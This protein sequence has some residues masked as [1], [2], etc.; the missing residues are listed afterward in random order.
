[1][2]KRI[3]SS[4]LR[5]NM[6]S[7]VAATASSAIILAIRYP[8]YLRFLGYEQY[9]VWLV[10]STVLTFAQL[11][12][13]GVDHAVM[14]LVAEEHGRRN[15]VAVQEYVSSAVAILA[16][17][18]AAVLSLIIT[19]RVPIIAVFKLSQENASHA[20]WLV[21]C[22]GCLS[23]YV[24]IVQTLSATLSGLGRMDLVN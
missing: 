12:N 4:Q 1:M 2:F 19:F 6:V 7:G 3:F 18:G 9:G 17:S 23:V 16:V 10:L 8:L 24:L 13:L 22:V 15:M 21:P 11:G 20:L 5:I 14:K